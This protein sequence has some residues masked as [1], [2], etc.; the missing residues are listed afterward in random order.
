M[1]PRKSC[2]HGLERPKEAIS[3]VSFP[4]IGSTLFDTDFYTKKISFG[5][6]KLV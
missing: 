1:A 6:K 2:A 4:D 5:V 3:D